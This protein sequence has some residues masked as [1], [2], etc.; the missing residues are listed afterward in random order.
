MCYL[1]MLNIFFPIFA[2]YIFPLAKH[3]I[4]CRSFAQQASYVTRV[5]SGKESKGWARRV[6]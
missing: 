4:I 2:E 6:Q 1:A 3:I 5:I